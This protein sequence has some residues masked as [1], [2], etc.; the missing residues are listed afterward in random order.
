MQRQTPKLNVLFKHAE[1]DKIDFNLQ[2]TLPHK[3]T[4]SGPGL[5]VGDINNDGLEDF[6]VGGSTLYNASVYKQKPD[7]TF[8]LAEKISKR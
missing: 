1:D 3:F 6:I 8:S 2:R 4:Q 5:C 7:G